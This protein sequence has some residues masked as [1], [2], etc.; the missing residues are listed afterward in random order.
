M[1]SSEQLQQRL[2]TIGASEVSAVVGVSPWQGA[3]D[4]WCRKAT[5]DNGEFP[6]LVPAE[7]DPPGVLGP[8]TVGNEV[9]ASTARLYGLCHPELRLEPSGTLV[10]PDYPWA[11]ATPDRLCYPIIDG[12]EVVAPL[13]GLEAKAVGWRVADHWD[14]GLPDYVACQCHW[15]MFVTNLPRWDAAALLGTE[16]RGPFVLSRDEDLI[17]SLVDVCGAFWR[18]NVLAHVPPAPS[19]ASEAIRLV[20][21]RFRRSTERVLDVGADAVVASLI[22]EYASASVRAKEADERKKEVAAKLCER[23]GD[24]SAM[25]G[26]WGKFSWPTIAGAVSWKSVAEELASGR[27]I[28]AVVARHR[29]AEYR[30]PGFYPKK[31]KH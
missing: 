24:A 20:G 4:I 8:R 13:H 18:D 30:K 3:A 22:E 10:H 25:T 6:P 19:N 21:A 7:Q 17:V 27:N 12:A 16:F 23:I 26:P 31:R 2:R 15:S 28:E 29:G 9:E 5:G 11:S 14:D 1:L